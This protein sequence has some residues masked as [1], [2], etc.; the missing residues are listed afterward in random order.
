MEL[1]GVWVIIP[2][3]LLSGIIYS[4]I[5]GYIDGAG[6]TS[7]SVFLSFVNLAYYIGGFFLR[8][9]IGAVLLPF[10]VPALGLISAAWLAA[11]CFYVRRQWSSRPSI[12]VCLLINVFLILIWNILVYISYFR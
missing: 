9:W 4:V 1:Q 6:L 2:L 7:F 8:P 5:C 3:V 11:A 10:V 12:A